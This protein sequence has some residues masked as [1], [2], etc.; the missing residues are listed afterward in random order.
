MKGPAEKKIA[1]QNAWFVAPKHVR[2][3]PAASQRAF[4][5]Y[6]I[7]KQCRRV[8]EFD[9][10]GEFHMRVSGDLELPG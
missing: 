10:S 4:V 6:V 9:G 8:D 5:H 1:N 2:R 3:G 7:V